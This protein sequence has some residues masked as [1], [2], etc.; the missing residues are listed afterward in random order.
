MPGWPVMQP[1]SGVCGSSGGI[2]IPTPMCSVTTTSPRS[3]AFTPSQRPIWQHFPQATHAPNTVSIQGTLT[4]R[5]GFGM[6]GV[7]VVARPLDAND[8]PLYQYTVSFVS[9]GYFS[10]K[11]GSLITGST[12]SNGNP[13]AMWGSND[14]TLQGFFDL[15]D[16]PLPPGMT[17][18]NY[19][20]TLKPSIPSTCSPN[21]SALMWTAL[22]PL[23][24]PCP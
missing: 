7:N 18:A 20:V 9:G 14:A 4:F 12:D 16:M 21:Q 6:Q 22:P 24:E 11:H 3:A 15:S 19:Q 2:C 1:L 5:A 13:L 10:G 17:T 23:P 8:N